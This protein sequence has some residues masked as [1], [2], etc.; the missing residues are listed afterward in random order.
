MSTGRKI[1]CTRATSLVTHHHSVFLHEEKRHWS[2]YFIIKLLYIYLSTTYDHFN[3][4][5]KCH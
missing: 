2:P 3:F 5:L 4:N 1:P